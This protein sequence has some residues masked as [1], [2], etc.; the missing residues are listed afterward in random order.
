[1]IILKILECILIFVVNSDA[2]L[3]LYRGV[4]FIPEYGFWGFVK[5][6]GIFAAILIFLWKLFENVIWLHNILQ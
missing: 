3:T 2:F 1:M 6:G 4:G 5:I